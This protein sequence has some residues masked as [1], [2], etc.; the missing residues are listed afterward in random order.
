M[1]DT[2]RRIADYTAKG[3][4]LVIRTYG[5]A[6]VRDFYD[7]GYKES[8]IY[9]GLEMLEKEGVITRVG[10]GTYRDATS[11]PS[12]VHRGISEVPQKSPIPQPPTRQRE[13]SQTSDLPRST[14]DPSEIQPES[15]NG[16]TLV[17]TNV[18]NVDKPPIPKI[19]STKEIHDF[20]LVV[21]EFDQELYSKLQ[22]RCEV[23][24]RMLDIE[25]I[26]PDLIW[27]IAASELF[28]GD[29]ITLEQINEW[30]K[31][32]QQAYFE[33]KVDKLWIAL[34]KLVKSFYDKRGV[35]W[36]PCRKPAV[37]KAF[38]EVQDKRLGTV[39]MDLLRNLDR[40]YSDY[41]V[42]KKLESERRRGAA[43]AT[44]AVDADTLRLI[45]LRDALNHGDYKRAQEL[46]TQLKGKQS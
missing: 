17:N 37:Y 38:R 9:R 5:T 12:E 44:L 46:K 30:R 11:D 26:S 15:P 8:A 13:N 33:K 21:Q 36:T 31:G 29:E 10:K 22:K 32:C 35:K 41:F 34:S 18:T 42:D 20:L 39:C 28:I 45:Q 23:Y 3:M 19:Q 25:G 1:K 43:A 27:R 6:T 24:S 16:L 2:L 14:S 7:A 4:Y 40:P